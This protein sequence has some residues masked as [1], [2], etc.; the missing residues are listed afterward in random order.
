MVMKLSGFGSLLQLMYKDKMDV[1]RYSQYE[2]EDGSTYIGLSDKPI[3]SQIPCRVSFV[4][5]DISEP[6]AEDINH[7]SLHIKIFCAANTD[8]K[9]GDKLVAYRMGDNGE[10][11]E[12]YTGKA[13]KPR[14]Y[15]THKEISLEEVGEA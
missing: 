4:T 14:Q 5:N 10:V 13:S 1:Y 15:V 7:L 6:T 11:L 2:E 3:Y 8:I 9:K 12:T